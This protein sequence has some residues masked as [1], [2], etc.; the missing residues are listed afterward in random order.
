[1]RAQALALALV[2]AAAAACGN[3]PFVTDLPARKAP[4]ARI[5]SP[6]GAMKSFVG[7]EMGGE[8]SYDPDGTVVEWEWRIASAPAGSGMTLDPLEGGRRIGLVPDLLGSY[9]VELRVVDDD[10]LRS[11]AAVSWFEIESSDGLR[12]ELAWDRDITDMDLHLIAQEP[13]NAF[14]EAPWDCFFQ[15]RT[16]DW[17]IA[18][19][20]DD[21][22]ILPIDQD[23]GFGPEV[24]G[25]ATPAAG[26]YR[27]LG[28]YYCD[29]GF[30]GTTATIRAFAD[31]VLLDERSAAMTATGDLWEWGTLT[32]STAGVATL[33]VSTAGV[34]STTRGC[35]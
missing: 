11:D 15:N 24:I 7:Y 23:D 27:V 16:P 35:E 18:G 8:G 21:D 14:F 17:G 28:H 26:S 2:G 10:G 5:D 32:Y 30:G 34:V 3:S 13:G 4:V 1:M 20:T 22:P 31:G 6:A 29:D 12:L 19:V 9:T 25:L 33:S